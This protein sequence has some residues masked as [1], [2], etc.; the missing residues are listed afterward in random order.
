M[1]RARVANL[2]VKAE[3]ARLRSA[4]AN[5]DL[6]MRNRYPDL[7]VGLSPTQMGSKVTTCP[8]APTRRA[9]NSVKIPS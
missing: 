8:V 6:T 1:G 3:A 5:R 7:N 2:N 9:K 4:Q